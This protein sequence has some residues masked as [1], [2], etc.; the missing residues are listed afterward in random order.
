MFADLRSSATTN[1]RPQVLVP[2]S[3]K[4]IDLKMRGAVKPG[5]TWGPEQASILRPGDWAAGTARTLSV[6]SQSRNRG[7]NWEFLFFFGCLPIYI[8]IPLKA[9]DG[10]Y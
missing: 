10:Y 5:S 1:R 3:R 6:S 9:P 8:R 2:G 4:F 7:E